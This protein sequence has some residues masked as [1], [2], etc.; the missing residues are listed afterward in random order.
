MNIK[1]ENCYEANCNKTTKNTNGRSNDVLFRENEQLKINIEKEL[2]KQDHLG[3]KHS[4]ESNLPTTPKTTEAVPPSTTKS[5]FGNVST[6]VKRTILQRYLNDT[7]LQQQISNYQDKTTYNA[8]SDTSSTLLNDQFSTPNKGNKINNTEK[9][10]KL[11]QATPIS[12]PLLTLTSFNHD[13]KSS[14]AY[15]FFN[16][17]SNVA[18]TCVNHSVSSEQQNERFELAI[19]ARI[20]KQNN[21]RIKN[22]EENFQKNKYF[23]LFKKQQRSTQN[24]SYDQTQKS[25]KEQTRLEK[26]SYLESDFLNRDDMP[27]SNDFIRSFNKNLILKSRNVNHSQLKSTSNKSQRTAQKHTSKLLNTTFK[28]HNNSF[29]N[30]KKHI[31][32]FKYFKKSHHK[33]GQGTNKRNPPSIESQSNYH[34]KAYQRSNYDKNENDDIISNHLWRKKTCGSM[35]SND[36]EEVSTTSSTSPRRSPS[37]DKVVFDEYT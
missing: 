30:S 24:D 37:C 13:P 33:R 26:L 31:N 4:T 12:K 28:T 20:K 21:E 6:K 22:K 3:A 11:I 34:Y 15:S 18:S 8:T 2:N 1:F 36:F 17:F 10:R 7:L 9:N 16:P 23:D 29:S 27:K 14:Q 19:S 32:T 25:I 5:P 35:S